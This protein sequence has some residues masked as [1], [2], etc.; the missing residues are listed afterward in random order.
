M[1]FS[2][3]K[4]SPVFQA[5]TAGKLIEEAYNKAKSKFSFKT[6]L[7][8]A[9]KQNENKVTIKIKSNFIFDPILLERYLQSIFLEKFYTVEVSVDI[10]TIQRNKE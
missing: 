3:K 6:D 2:K 4:K 7:L 5:E 10:I 8:I 9:T 1:C